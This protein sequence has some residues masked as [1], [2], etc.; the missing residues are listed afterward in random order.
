MGYSFMAV[1]IN[2]S[3][4]ILK[5]VRERGRPLFFLWLARPAGKPAWPIARP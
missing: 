2:L 4:A 1:D 5:G 3:K